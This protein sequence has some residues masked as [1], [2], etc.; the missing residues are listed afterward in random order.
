MFD[1]GHFSPLSMLSIPDMRSTS[2]GPR[3]KQSPHP[4]VVQSA[5][6]NVSAVLFECCKAKR[7]GASLTADAQERA[8]PALPVT[9]TIRHSVARACVGLGIRVRSWL[10]APFPRPSTAVDAWVCRPTDG[11]VA[12]INNPGIIRQHCRVSSP[13]LAAERGV[14]PWMSSLRHCANRACGRRC[15]PQSSAPPRL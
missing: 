6:T 9:S 1:L 7:G 11:N 8:T 12:Q 2:A 5:H 4:E 3:P 15:Q 10:P 13:V 14:A